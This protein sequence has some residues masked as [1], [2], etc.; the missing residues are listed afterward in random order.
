M[1]VLV[2][3]AAGRIGRAVYV[4]LAREHDVVG[5]DR[6][7][8]STAELTGD[9]GDRFLL[10]RALRDVDAVVHCAGLHAPQVG[11]VADTEFRRVNV[12]AS[13]MLAQ[14]AR[15][16]GIRRF[17]FTS[18]TALY[19]A[20]SRH[21][22]QAVWTDECLSPQPVSIYH[23]T[24]LAAESALA[25]LAHAG[26]AVTILRMSRCFPEPAPLMAAYRLHRGV[27]ARDVASAHALALADDSPGLRRFVIS[28]ATP[29]Q[30]EDAA[31]LLA[32]AGAV[33]RRRAPALVAV[34]AERGW[35]LPR[36]VD[37]VYSPA[38]AMAQLNW[39]PRYG[40]EEVLRQFDEESS[41]V[42]PPRHPVR[43]AEE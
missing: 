35:A 4:H 8:A 33:L 26:M 1:R 27:D 16:A 10:R 39:R 36:S 11:F 24:K 6:A 13:V 41:E 23:R 21:P 3:G 32:D 5:L 29:F 31:E 28:G 22:T 25:K 19:G 34:F 12:D 42:L 9:L 38:A 15:E 40:F 20:A 37:R 7:P 17:V 18:T 14:M 2:T 43:G 30:P